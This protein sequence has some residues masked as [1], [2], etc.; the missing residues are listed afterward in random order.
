[1]QVQLGSV[2]K[3]LIKSWYICLKNHSIN[4][5]ICQ[6]ISITLHFISTSYLFL[7]NLLMRL[8]ITPFCVGWSLISERVKTKL[9]SGPS[10]KPLCVIPLLGDI[11]CCFN[12]PIQCFCSFS[13]WV[14]RTRGFSLPYPQVL[15]AAP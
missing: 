6:P 11:P 4:V 3:D 12:P 2:T 13:P 14:V 1:M 5:L 15:K 9:A 10:L 7:C 8:G